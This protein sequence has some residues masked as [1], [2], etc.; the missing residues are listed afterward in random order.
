MGREASFYLTNKKKQ[1]LKER[2]LT[3]IKDLSPE[4]LNKSGDIFVN[5]FR[6]GGPYYSFVQ[7]LFILGSNEYHNEITV[8]N[9]MRDIMVSFKDKK[10]NNNWDKFINK[11]GKGG[12][13]TLNDS[14]GRIHLNARVLQRLNGKTPYGNT[15]RQVLSCIDIR[16]CENNF[17]EFK[18]NTQFNQES[19]V[20]PEFI[21]L[22]EKSITELEE[23]VIV[24]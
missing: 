23:P 11:I 13:Y 20:C 14:R 18:L 15:L 24:N 2:F 3:D 5:P 8:R 6:R 12:D 10:G 19:E 4:L 9:K 7:A 21:N 17:W 1:K 16:I 22:N